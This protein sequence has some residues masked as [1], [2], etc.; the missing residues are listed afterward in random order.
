ME[1]Q[2]RLYFSIKT[3]FKQNAQSTI[4]GIQTSFSNF[5]NV[6]E[7]CHAAEDYTFSR[8][9]LNID[10]LYT[11]FYYSIISVDIISGLNLYNKV[12]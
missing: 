3:F 8:G 2:N 6:N 12:A 1:Y 4:R 9:H 10:N 11:N 5:P 7:I